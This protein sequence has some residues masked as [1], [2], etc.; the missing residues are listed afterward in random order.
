MR[1][2][3]SIRWIW[4]QTEFQMARRSEWIKMQVFPEIARVHHRSCV[5][6]LQIRFREILNQ[7]AQ[8][9]YRS[10]PLST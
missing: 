4:R 5:L 2:Q 3:R 10:L 1:C 6:L 9:L 7:N 8:I